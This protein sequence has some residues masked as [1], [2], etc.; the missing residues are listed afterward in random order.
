M[1]LLE[2]GA[3]LFDEDRAMLTST[4]LTLL[5]NRRSGHFSEPRHAAR[6]L[7]ALER[8]LCASLTHEPGGD[9]ASAARVTD[10]TVHISQTSTSY[11]GTRIKGLLGDDVSEK[12]QRLSVI[13]GIRIPGREIGSVHTPATTTLI[14]VIDYL[15]QQLEQSP[16]GSLQFH[17]AITQYTTFMVCFGLAHRGEKMQPLP[18]LN[19]IDPDTGFLNIHDTVRTDKRTHSRMVWVPPVIRDQLQIYE[20]YLQTEFPRF[21][22]D[23]RAHVTELLRRG[24][25]PLVNLRER[26]WCKWATK[27]VYDTL[28][29]RHQRAGAV[30]LNAGRHWLRTQM[31]GYCSE[32]TINAFLG[33]WYLGREPWSFGSTLDPFR[34]RADLEK[35]LPRLLAGLGLKAMGGL[36][37]SN[38]N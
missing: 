8:F 22:A 18:A 26:G 3:P 6:T 15:H 14:A 4:I 37:T 17:L 19:A 35:T 1:E 24:E 11:G 33:H 20:S 31:L 13:G 2:D 32:E 21:P 5:R 25:L 30:K 23:L 38:D 28:P 9:L 12:R 29:V 16:V 7:E 27:D 36:A 34:Y 10:N